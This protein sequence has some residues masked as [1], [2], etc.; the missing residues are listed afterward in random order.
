MVHS[1]T[2]FLAW[3]ALGAVAFGAGVV[4]FTPQDS[5]YLA[6]STKV[7][8]VA[9]HNGDNLMSYSPPNDWKLSGGGGRLTLTPPNVVQAGAAM[10]VRRVGEPVPA[11]EENVKA[12]ADVAAKYL[13]KEATKVTVGDSGIANIRLGKYAMVEVN[14]TYSLFGQAYTTNILFMPYEKQQQVT[15]QVTAKSADFPAVSKAFR[16]SLYSLQGF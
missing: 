10:E 7:P 11:T 3:A 2:S 8:C 16:R 14:L 1:I 5:F 9:F 12:Y 15:F 6:E 4:D 13:P